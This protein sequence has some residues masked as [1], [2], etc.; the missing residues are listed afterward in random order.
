MIVCDDRPPGPAGRATSYYYVSDKSA[1]NLTADSKFK[2][3]PVFFE[4]FSNQIKSEAAARWSGT[5]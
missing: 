2:P 5:R 3:D 4:K 1:G